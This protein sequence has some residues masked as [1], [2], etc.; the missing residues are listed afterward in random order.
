MSNIYYDIIKMIEAL[1]YTKYLNLNNANSNFCNSLIR[2]CLS[3]P[4]ILE[5]SNPSTYNKE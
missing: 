1:F 2:S 3:N 5:Y 4:Q